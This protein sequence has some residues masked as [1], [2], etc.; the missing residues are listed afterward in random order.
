MFGCE[1][2][3]GGFVLLVKDKPLVG[4][5]AYISKLKWGVGLKKKLQN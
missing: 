3:L 4:E 2:G 5:G 1:A